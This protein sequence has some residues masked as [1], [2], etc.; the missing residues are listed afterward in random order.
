VDC[1]EMNHV[2]EYLRDTMEYELS[3]L[4]GHKMDL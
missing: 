4:G 2:L 1:I 3:Y